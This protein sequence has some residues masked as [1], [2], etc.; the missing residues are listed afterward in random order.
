FTAN[1]G[2]YIPIRIP[3]TIEM[4][5]HVVSG[6]RLMC[7][8]ISVSSTAESW[9]DRRRRLDWN[10]ARSAPQRRVTEAVDDVQRE[11]YQEPPSKTHQRQMREP[12]HDEDAKQRSQRRH[13]PDERHPERAATLRLHVSQNQHSDADQRE[14][15]QR[16]D[17]SQVVGLA[18]ITDQRPQRDECTGEQSGYVG[19][20]VFS[21]NLARPNGQQP[22][23]R[24]RE[25]YPGL[26]V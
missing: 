24:H 20:P 1:S 26:T 7:R 4:M 25:E 8:I 18:R 19:C 21:V 14:R 23:A 2:A 3:T 22:V 9:L 15:E 10:R 17:V 11:A 16:T 13:H 6:N 5:I 12:S